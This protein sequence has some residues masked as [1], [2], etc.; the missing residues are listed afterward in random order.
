MKINRDE[1]SIIDTLLQGRCDSDC[2]ATHQIHDSSTGQSLFARRP[3]LDRMNIGTA[4]SHYR[5]IALD[6]GTPLAFHHQENSLGPKLSA[7]APR[8]RLALGRRYERQFDIRARTSGQL[9]F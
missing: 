6:S 3:V 2:T 9:F 1:V 8:S 7:V 5:R 4:G